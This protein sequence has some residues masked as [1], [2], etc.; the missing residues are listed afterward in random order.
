MHAHTKSLETFIEEYRVAM[1][2]FDDRLERAAVSAFGEPDP[3]TYRDGFEPPAEPAEV[4]CWHCG[5]RYQS[6]EMRLRYKPR[7]QGAVVSA[8]GN[9]FRSLSPLWW[10]KNA[11][12][13]GGGFG[14]DIHPVKKRRKK[15]GRT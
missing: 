8:L 9:G 7:M 14:H 12:C 2:E 1:M 3:L 5:D 6:S 13:D 15:G 4:E 10:C 11:D